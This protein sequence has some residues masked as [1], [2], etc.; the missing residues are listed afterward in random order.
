M[1][2]VY[3][4]LILKVEELGLQIF[5]DSTHH[6]RCGGEAPRA[7]FSS[8]LFTSACRKAQLFHWF[9]WCVATKCFT[10]KWFMVHWW[11]PV[12]GSTGTSFQSDWAVRLKSYTLS[13]KFAPLKTWDPNIW[14]LAVHVHCWCWVLK[15]CHKVS[16]ECGA[17]WCCTMVQLLWLFRVEKGGG[18]K[19]EEGGR[20]KGRIRPL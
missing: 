20:P 11:Q 9:L 2:P 15:M 16:Q 6:S 10:A 13:R 8:T 5:L 3:F 1:T 7:E 4:Y 12:L 19:W 14:C 17:S 18:W